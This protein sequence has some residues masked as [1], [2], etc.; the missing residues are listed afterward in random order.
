MSQLDDAAALFARM[1][2]Q[3]QQEAL[4]VLGLS[5]SAPKEPQEPPKA[6]PFSALASTP[7]RRKRQPLTVKAVR[8]PDP[9]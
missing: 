8:G 5:R 6:T 9:V 3:G 7:S 4:R 1:S 2:P